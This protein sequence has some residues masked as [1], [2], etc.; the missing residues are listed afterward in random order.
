LLPFAEKPAKRTRRP[1]LLEGFTK[2]VEVA[3]AK[4]IFNAPVRDFQGI[5]VGPYKYVR[6]AGGI[7]ELYDLRDD[8]AELHSRV[9][10]P[11]YRDVRAFLAQRLNRLRR[12]AG[13]ACRRPLR[14]KIP[15]P[16]PIRR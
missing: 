6:Y 4:P 15:N 2:A 14:A 9:S 1:L 16:L 10:D 7:R 12:C 8:P 11:R 3:T 5:R 13:A